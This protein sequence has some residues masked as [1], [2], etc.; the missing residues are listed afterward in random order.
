MKGMNGQ[1]GHALSGIGHLEQSLQDILLT[2]VGTRLMRRDY[3]SLLPDLIDQPLNSTTILQSYAAAA[4]AISQWE[5]RIR[6]N[7]IQR[8]V[9]PIRPGTAQ[10]NIDCIRL[11]TGTP[12]RAQ[13]SLALPAGASSHE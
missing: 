5:P 12:E 7:S 3:G 10:L 4:I 6:L 13:L 8:R 9:D 2:P 11:D 1:T